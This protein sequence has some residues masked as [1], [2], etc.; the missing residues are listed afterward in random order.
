MRFGFQSTCQTKRVLRC[1]SS[2]H[3]LRTM[4]VRACQVAQSRPTPRPRGL[5]DGCACV[6]SR[7]VMSNS[8]TPWTVVHQTPL[9]MRFSRQEY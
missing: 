6:L 9:S 5:D 7:S 4:G 2:S 1:A 8:A 3:S